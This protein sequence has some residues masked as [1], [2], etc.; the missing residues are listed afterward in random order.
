MANTLSSAGYAVGVRLTRLSLRTLGFRRTIAAMKSIPRPLVVHPSNVA[1]A[2]KW[3][4]AI[5]RVGGRPYGATCLDRS[6]LL[7]LLMRQRGLD[8]RLRI[9]VAFDDDELNA[10]AWV[11]STGR[12]I[13]D[14]PQVAERFAV[15]ESDPTGLVFS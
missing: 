7:W 15:F 14:D 2:S 8:P 11:E 13:N 10:H 5:A 4:D 3:A 6:V 1:S 12:V 9:G